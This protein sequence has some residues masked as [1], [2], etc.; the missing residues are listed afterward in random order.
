MSFRVFL[1]AIKLNATSSTIKTVSSSNSSCSSFSSLLTSSPFIT[2]TDSFFWLLYFS[3]ISSLDSNDLFVLKQGMAMWFVWSSCSF[4][5]LKLFWVLRLPL[6]AFFFLLW[7]TAELRSR[8]SLYK[9][10]SIKTLKLNLLPEFIW[11]ETI[12]CWLDGPII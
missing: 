1:N 5:D 12:S 9:G 6:Y 8:S 11:D 3:S 4:S 7:G 10:W 2:F